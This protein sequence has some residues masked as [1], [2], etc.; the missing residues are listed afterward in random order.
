MREPAQATFTYLSSLLFVIVA[1]ANNGKGL[2]IFRDLSMPKKRTAGFW[3]YVHSDDKHDGGRIVRL[4]QRL[5]ESIRFFSGVSDFQIFLDR[6]DIGWGEK[7]A[8]RISNELEDALVLFPVVTPRYFGSQACR[9]EII[10]FSKREAKLDRDD[11]ILPLY[12][13]VADQVDGS[14]EIAS[15]EEDEVATLMRSR[16]YEDWRP[17]E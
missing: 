6:K 3:S 9:E 14:G 12:Y 15:A 17:C 8:D 16:Q 7:W 13:V 1:I 4:R 5:E 11:L 10:A 2:G